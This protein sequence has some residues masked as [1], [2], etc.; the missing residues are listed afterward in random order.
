MNIA[1]ISGSASRTIAMIESSGRTRERQKIVAVV[2]QEIVEMENII[3]M[4]MSPSL[5][6]R[7][8]GSTSVDTTQLP[9]WFNTQSRIGIAIRNGRQKRTT[10]TLIARTRPREIGSCVS[11]TSLPR[12]SLFMSEARS[13]L[14]GCF[15]AEA[16]G[17]QQYSIRTLLARTSSTLPASVRN[18]FVDFPRVIVDDASLA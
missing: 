12:F 7:R 1:G 6:F 16:E 10:P 3:I 13:F 4:Y 5:D 11:F 2:N 18:W 9:A 14:S 15:Q 8:S 17:N